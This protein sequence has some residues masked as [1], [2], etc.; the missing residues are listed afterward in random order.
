MK[1][2]YKLIIVVLI[3]ISCESK[4]QEKS[5]VNESVKPNILWITCEDMS[6]RLGCYGDTVV[7]TPN[8]DQL[9]LE[10]MRFTNFYGVAGVCAPNRSAIITGMYP[11]SYGAM[12]MRTISRTASIDKVTDP[13]AL[14]I[15]VYEATPPPEV[16][17]FTEFLRANGYFCTNNVKTDYQFH[18]PVTAW[19]ENSR[20]AHWRNR[21]EGMPFFS[22][23]NFT[24]THESQVW[25]RKDEPLTVD[26]EK[27]PVPPYYPDSPV[28]RKDIAR[29]YSNIEVMD[30]QVGEVLNQLKED[31]LADNTI[32]FFYSDHGDGLPR[33]KRW[34]YDS[35]IEAPMII[36]FPDGRYAGEINDQLISFID[37][38]P[39][40]LSL[41]GIPIP[42]YMHGQA[43]L[44]NQ[45]GNER[46][47]IFA[48]KDR[49]DPALDRARAVRDKRFKY[50][51]NYKP[52]KPFVQFIPYRDQMDLM[53]E[54]FR[55]KNEGKLDPVQ[56]IW[57]SDQKPVEELYDT[58]N[59]PH[60]I[61]N[62]ADDPAYGN[63]LVRMR[64]KH[65][66]WKEKYGDL[67]D[68]PE[69]ELV[70]ILWPPLGEQP[71][72]EA[73]EI[74]I[75]N[76]SLEPTLE[77]NTPTEGAS[78]AYQINGG[79]WW[80]YDHPV[81]I[82]DRAEIKAKAIRIGFKESELVK[83]EFQLTNN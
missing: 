33:A 12:H 11:T 82:P 28:I 67:G 14:A 59:D 79:R 57:F 43:F 77:I 32:V 50:I 62:I 23:F 55:F 69:E 73:P 18:P 34:L 8:I 49:M 81:K 6:P 26:P 56:E 41:T 72:T 21:P 2:I 20:E 36:R 47:Y 48:A 74:N 45:S 61:N 15:P 80:L 40:V 68:L 24:V 13:E 46:E 53:Q 70:R 63:I 76:P 25:R 39:T 29:H 37:L 31:G 4:K 9:A 71:Q 58:R 66:E 27:V 30:Q 64:E 19:D 10:G 78:I 60:E 38:A 3:L 83:K 16:K 44:G 17:C 54:L 1:D 51:L 75:L 35:G 22:V 5:I 52:S 65:F 42:G 7:E